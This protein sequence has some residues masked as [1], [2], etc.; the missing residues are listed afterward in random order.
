M[1]NAGI[2]LG[3]VVGLI[4]LAWVFR[5][6]RRDRLYVGYG[7]IFVVG[8]I[9]ALAVLIV[10]PLLDAVAAASEALLPVA[11]LSLVALLIMLLLLVYVFTQITVLS[12]RIMRL[13]Q[14]LAI[15]GALERPRAPDAADRPD[16][17]R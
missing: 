1:T 2:T 15:R 13:T 12:N 17:S 16:G 9:A 5:L 3:V 10:R 11:S 4:L 8:T 6:I 14:E 7:V